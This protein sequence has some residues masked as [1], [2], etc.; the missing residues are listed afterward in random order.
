MRMDAH[1][2]G[3]ER[4]GAADARGGLNSNSSRRPLSRSTRFVLHC[5]LLG[6]RIQRRVGV[7]M[8][9]IEQKI[10]DVNGS[11]AIEGMPLTEDDKARLRSILRGE[12]D[13]DTA[14]QDIIIKYLMINTVVN[15]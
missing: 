5:L 11:M 13:Y 15:E 2:S 4:D 10:R 8:R 9:D 12:I 3:K 6:S 1:S 14:I 7:K